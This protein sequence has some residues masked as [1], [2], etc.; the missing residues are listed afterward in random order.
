M[1]GY[2]HGEVQCLLDVRRQGPGRTADGHGAPGL[3][4]VSLQEF[5]RITSYNVCYTKLL[6]VSQSFVEGAEDVRAVREAAAAGG[7][8]P[9]VIAK[10]ERARALD[11]VA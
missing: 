2:V 1:P 10:I 9:F 7:H 5:V 4:P 6:R 11:Q 3:D 8:A